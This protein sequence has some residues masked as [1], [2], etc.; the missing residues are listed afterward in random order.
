MLPSLRLD[1]V[2]DHLLAKHLAEFSARQRHDNR[3]LAA[4]GTAEDAAKTLAAHIRHIDDVIRA[5]VAGQVMPAH[6]AGLNHKEVPIHLQAIVPRPLND[7]FRPGGL[8]RV[9]RSGDPLGCAAAPARPNSRAA[10]PA[11]DRHNALMR[12]PL[13]S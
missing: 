13:A 11:I 10:H 1:L 2:A 3:K 7:G 6:R 4:A 5:A 8:A 12:P 9:Q